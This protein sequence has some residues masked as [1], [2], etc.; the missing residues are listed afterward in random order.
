MFAAVLFCENPIICSRQFPSSHSNISNNVRVKLFNANC[1]K[2]RK[3]ES[4]AL[5]LYLRYANMTII[6]VYHNSHVKDWSVVAPRCNFREIV[7]EVM[8]L[9][10][11]VVWA[12]VLKNDCKIGPLIYILTGNKRI[13]VL[14]QL[15]P[16][17]SR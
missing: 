7:G 3:F 12:L 2:C 15:F 8:G 10:L 14:E 13:H 11:T 16:N 5:S 6:D 1:M 9:S 4:N 17:F